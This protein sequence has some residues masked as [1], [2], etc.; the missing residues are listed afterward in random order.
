MGDPSV[1]TGSLTI[2]LTQPAKDL[3]IT[4]NGVLVAQR[5]HTDRVHVANIPIGMADVVIAA[6]GGPTRIDRHF[7][8]SIDSGAVA[9]VP[10]AA[11]DRA[12]SS[13]LPMW[14][15]SLLATSITV[16]MQLLL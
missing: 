8:V 15:L 11:P 12:M 4:V 3:T 13:T 14:F 5:A 2:L 6:G 1:L 16:T 7:Q 10:I 9:T